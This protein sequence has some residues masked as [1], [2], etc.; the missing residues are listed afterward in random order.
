MVMKRKKIICSERE[1]ELLEFVPDLYL[2]HT[3]ANLALTQLRKGVPTWASQEKNREMSVSVWVYEDDRVNAFCCYKDGHNYIALS[4]GIFVEYW[5]AANDFVNHERFSLVFKLAADRKPCVLNA[6]FFSM[7]NFTIAHEFGH[8]AHGHLRVDSY[9]N[10]IDEVLEITDEGNSNTKN[11]N[12][13]L[14]EYDA[15][16]FAVSIQALLLLQE[17]SDEI[18]TNIAS[19]DMLFIAN[20]LCFLTFAEKTGRNFDKYMEKDIAEVDHPHPGIRM[21]YAV[22]LYSYWIG[23]IKGYNE[24]VLYAL[25]SGTHAVVAYEKTVVESKKIKECYFSVAFTEKGCQHI[26]N[27]NNGWQELVDHYNQ[28]AYI[29]IEKLGDID[30]LPVSVNE[31]GTFLKLKEKGN[32]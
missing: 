14:K 28:Y 25:S 22:L 4:V 29:P 31:N 3:E 17:W 12:T 6:L 20:Y 10:V 7:L 2:I 13:Q 11:W 15:D 5:K 23:R 24:D 16:S 21:Y 27:L 1:I 8:I 30:S 19:V 32:E 18:K 9:C 26:M